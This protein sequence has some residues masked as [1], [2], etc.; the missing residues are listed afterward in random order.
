MHKF[1]V[2]TYSDSNGNL[3]IADRVPYR[4]FTEAEAAAIRGRTSTATTYPNR[5]YFIAEGLIEIALE[6]PPIITRHLIRA[7]IK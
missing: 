6:A 5:K 1:F 4:T 3:F 2:V 7:D